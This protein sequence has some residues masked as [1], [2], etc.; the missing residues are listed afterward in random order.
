MMTRFS[1][2]L[3][4]GL[5]MAV[6][7]VPA[8]LASG[9]GTAVGVD[10][11][12]VARINTGDRELIVGADVSVGETVITGPRGQVQIVFADQTRLAVGPS[13][14]LK[15]EEYL[16]RS[17]GTA[18]AFVVN[19]LA[20]TF[21]FISGH[22]PKSAYQINTP[23]ATIAVR[24]TEFDIVVSGGATRV[25]LFDGA[26]SMCN[27]AQDCTDLTERCQLGL[28]TGQNATLYEDSDPERLPLSADFY[29]VRFQSPLR[30]DFRVNG[31]SRC[32]VETTGTMTTDEI[33]GSD[34]DVLL[35]PTRSPDNGEGS[36]PPDPPPSDPSEQVGR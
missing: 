33:G 32:L 21:R 16:L 27:D 17:N 18:D 28:A 31:A 35:P 9:E 12:A 14:S 23:T 11:E 26:L 30:P 24:G 34:G 4:A 5:A 10:P 15:I 19:A 36:T 29:Y 13:S 8:A 3:Y 20:G 22:S 25:I 7:I 2:T 1:Q 6:L